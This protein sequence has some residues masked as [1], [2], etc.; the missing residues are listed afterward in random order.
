MGTIFT[1]SFDS[2]IGRLTVA[3]TD[4][5][6][7]YIAL[8]RANGRGLMGWRQRHAPDDT[9][10]EGFEPNRT[11]IAQISEFVDG[12]REVFD[13]P[14]DLRGTP[15]QR[16]VY[17]EVAGILYGEW[18]SYSEIARRVG[19]PKAVRAVGA[20][21][22][23][24]PLPLVIPCHRVLSRAGQLQGYAGGLDMKAKL[25]AMEKSTRPG[26]IKLF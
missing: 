13:L 26:Q 16:D 10:Q 7:A 17:R 23:A 2:T 24:N 1:A 11:A 12:K 5:G 4:A 19:R 21:N 20:A 15:F 25:L 22:G 14:I 18:C 6:V 8:P 9:L 3:S